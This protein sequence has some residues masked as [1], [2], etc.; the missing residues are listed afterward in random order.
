MDMGGGFLTISWIS[1]VSAI[2]ITRLGFSKYGKRGG[3]GADHRPFSGGQTTKI[4][5]SRT[6]SGG[7]QSSV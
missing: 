7:L 5:P 2:S 4:Q 1:E 6:C 3:E